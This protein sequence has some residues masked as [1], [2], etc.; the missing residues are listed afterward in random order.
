MY[1]YPRL[2]GRSSDR[3]RWLNANVP[4]FP[5]LKYSHK[6]YPKAVLS[7]YVKRGEVSGQTDILHS[8]DDE[9]WRDRNSERAES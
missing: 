9:Q 2:I 5:D 4:I 1:V 7:I 6:G 3:Y 8:D